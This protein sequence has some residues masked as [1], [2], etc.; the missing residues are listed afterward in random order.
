MPSRICSKTETTDKEKPDETSYETDNHVA[1]EGK[2]V[3][4][5]TFVDFASLDKADDCEETDVADYVLQATS[6]YN[7]LVAKDV[8][9][10]KLRPY[11]TAK[12]SG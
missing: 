6:Y 2:Q 3:R 5:E 11:P 12:K 10:S 7:Y 1:V 9:L 8:V 4:H